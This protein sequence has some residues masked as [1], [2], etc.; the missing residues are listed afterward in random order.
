VSDRG[1]ILDV[2]LAARTTML[3]PRGPVCLKKDQ[4]ATIEVQ[5]QA[6][7]VRYVVWVSP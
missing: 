6:G 2:T 4:A 3:G 5:G 1:R 7:P